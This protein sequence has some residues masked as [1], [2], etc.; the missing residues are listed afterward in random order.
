MTPRVR[1]AVFP[2]SPVQISSDWVRS[3]GFAHRVLDPRTQS[4]IATIAESG[5]VDYLFVP[6]KNTVNTTSQDDPTI[7]G[8][9]WFE[10]V[11]LMS[12]LAA[13][14]TH[15]G[16]V[17]TASTRWSEPYGLARMFASLDHLC[18]GRAGWNAV[19]S[20]PGL[21]DHNFGHLPTVADEDGHRRHREFIEVV[22]RLWESWDAD[23]VVA[24]AEGGRWARPGSVRR[25]DHI[26]QFFQ[27][28]GPLNV[29]RSPQDRPVV[30]Q[31]GESERFRGRAA[32]TADIVFTRFRNVEEGRTFTT[33]LR[34][35]TEQAGRAPGSVLVMP[36]AVV[37]L[38]GRDRTADATMAAHWHFRGSAADVADQMIDAVAAGAADGFTV[39]PSLLPDELAEFVGVVIP[40]LQ[41]VGAVP[42]MYRGTTLRE[43]LG[44]PTA[45]L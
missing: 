28:A 35:R 26:G 19:S 44:L 13:T 21:E 20:H 17:A 45:A 40:E 42:T 39:L 9:A 31:A 1:L 23:A 6:D 2:M 4:A 29:Q 7:A 11:T 10:P 8:N 32:E 16:L 37:S 38:G 24:D 25:I 34:R 36:S 18:S 5:I 22:L 12:Y 14:T 15:V 27:V 3:P 30:V 33:D 41:R 43:N